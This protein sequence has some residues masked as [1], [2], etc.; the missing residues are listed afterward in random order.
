M[1]APANAVKGG[2][3][4]EMT[5]HTPGPWMLVGSHR[6]VPKVLHRDSDRRA[7]FM[8]RVQRDAELAGAQRSV[9]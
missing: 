6:G 5:K 8:V 4:A 7:A 9:R 3:E 1:S 2:S